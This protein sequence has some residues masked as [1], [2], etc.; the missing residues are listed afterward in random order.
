ML[1]CGG[2]MTDRSDLKYRG[3]P[4]GVTQPAADAA[5]TFIEELDLVS[6]EVEGLGRVVANAR[7][8]ADPVEWDWRIREGRAKLAAIEQRLTLVRS[9]LEQMSEHAPKTTD[10]ESTDNPPR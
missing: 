10:H 9:A 7:L 8:T 3:V 2:T 1:F 5:W 4:E 6:S